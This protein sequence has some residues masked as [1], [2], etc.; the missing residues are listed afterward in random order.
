MPWAQG[1]CKEGNRAMEMG[2]RSGNRIIPSF[3]PQVWT[4][5]RWLDR[6][7]S[8]PG[9]APA[10]APPRPRPCS[11]QTG[12]WTSQRASSTH[13]AACAARL[14][15]HQERA[16]ARQHKRCSAA[17]EGWFSTHGR[18]QNKH[19]RKSPNQKGVGAWQ[20][21]PMLVDLAPVVGD[22]PVSLHQLHRAPRVVLYC[23]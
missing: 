15:T 10:A 18:Q 22:L 1:T 13:G 23:D 14:P 6:R 20:A 7:T 16:H 2:A 11:S 8:A 19:T 12:G 4:A 3:R 21:S 17:P 9:P 5:G